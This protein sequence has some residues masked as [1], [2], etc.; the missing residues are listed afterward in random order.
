M[1]KYEQIF[2]AYKLGDKYS[3]DFDYDGMLNMIINLKPN[4]NI[5]TLEKLY[6][7]STDV[8]YHSIG[9]HLWSAIEMLKEGDKKKAAEHIQDAIKTAKEELDWES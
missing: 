8:N 1:K 6:N 5:K 9:R 3:R 4:A 2:E 7:S